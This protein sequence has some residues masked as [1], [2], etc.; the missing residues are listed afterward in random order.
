MEQNELRQWE[1][2]CIE[3]QAPWCA[4]AC[5]LHVDARSLCARTAAG[6]WAGAWQVLLRTMPLPG[7]LGRIC[8]APC[9][10]RCKRGEAGEAIAIHLLERACVGHARP[11]RKPAP[12]PSKPQRIMVVGSGLSGLSA[13][14]ELARKGYQVTVHEPGESLAQGLREQYAAQVPDE[15]LDLELDLLLK[16]KI[17]VETR[18][19][20]DEPGFLDRML[21]SCDGVF[22]SLDAL[23]PEGWPLER[24]EDG[25][26]VAAWPVQATAR[27]G[28]F[29]GGLSGPDGFSPVWAAAQGRWGAASLDRWL[30]GVSPGAA[31]EKDGPF[32]TRLYIS[33]KGVEP[34]PK[35]QPAEP[36]GYDDQEA[37]QE[38]G[39]CLQ[40]HCLECVKVCPYL[41]SFG[42]YPKKYAREIYNNQSIV[43]GAR[44]ANKLINS[45]SLC[46]LCET[47]C[48]EDFAMQDLCLTVRRDMVQ[49]GKM[50]PSAH[51]FALL[52]MEFSLG[53]EFR[54]AKH[55][56]GHEAS[57]AL[58]YPGCQLAASA[59]S[60]VRAVYGHLCASLQ[61]GVGL[62]L[63]CCGAPAFW[64]G[65]EAKLASALEAWRAGWEALGSP[66]LI[67]ACS[68]C[69]E[70]FR[71]HLPEV[72]QRFLWEVLAETGME[73][74]A[75]ANG[76]LAM[77][78]PCT[79]RHHAD[80]QQTVRG[81]V[82][83]AGV[84]LE[85][86]R[87]GRELTECCG[88]GGLM[89]TANPELAQEVI[90]RRGGQSQ[91]DYL[92]YCAVCRDRLA[93]VG[94]RA[95]H[96]LDLFFPVPGEEDPAARPSPGWSQRRENRARLKAELL[97]DLWGEE[98]PAMQA[99]R[100]VELLIAPEVAEL[101]ER[102]RILIEDIQKVIFEAEAQG[103]KLCHPQTGHFLAS[104][105]PYKAVFWVEYTPE[106]EGFRVHNAY[107]HRMKVKVGAKP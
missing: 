22:L 60:Q 39:R 101:M 29:A 34:L 76:P 54:L 66:P 41:E 36:E 84:E 20:V 28:V 24:G 92:A 103:N 35:V 33:L 3:E 49:K 14:G 27:E 64:A 7:V 10:E 100:Q 52:D 30:Q 107:A 58:F 18:A 25:R 77:H 91:R 26:P 8:D 1:S 21:E 83:R 88:Y 55:Q 71:R 12:V 23:D 102:R 106:G 82:G 40:C 6:D 31:R 16:L 63:A 61:G 59:P 43:M 46:G 53:Q 69:A 37:I 105:R 13:A 80:I 4:A 11:R 96:A 95:L 68:S 15:A 65:Q 86:L 98:A 47:V 72:E 32:E 67:M 56:P 19:P 79:T 17:K 48:P 5:P 94:K 73:I 9:R 62:M 74:K 38:A 97:R 70:V 75:P 85:E 51:E 44:Q 90:T 57:A 50:P 42:A 89:S 99:H 87:L 78:D 93:Q 81:V 45:C 2:R 104:F